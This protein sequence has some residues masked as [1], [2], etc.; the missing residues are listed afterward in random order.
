VILGDGWSEVPET[1]LW[2]SLGLVLSAP[3]LVVTFGFLYA[4][5]RGG[6]VAAALVANTLVWFAVTIAL[7]PS[8]GPVAVGVGWVPAGIVLAVVTG[9][10]TRQR[11]G[12]AIG[13]SLALPAF[14][15]V[16]SGAA[17]WAVAVTGPESLLTAAAA[18]AAGE[19]LLVATLGVVRR[20]LL[21]DTYTLLARAVARLRPGSV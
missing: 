4:D 12:A 2:S 1:L 17:G 3:V 13:R 5:D 19:L 18:V 9:R 6:T 11:T 14:A 16:G 7:L 15:A 21:V 8:L 10:R 20:S